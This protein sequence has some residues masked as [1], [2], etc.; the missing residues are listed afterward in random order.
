MHTVSQAITFHLC[1]TIGQ[2]KASDKY[3]SVLNVTVDNVSKAQK[4]AASFWAKGIELQQVIDEAMKCFKAFFKW[5]HIEILRLSDENVS[6]DLNK[7]TQQDIEFIAQFLQSFSQGIQDDGHTYLE[8]VGQYLKEEKLTQPV[9]RSNNRWYSF[10][11]E[12]QDISSKVPEILFIDDQ[13]S[14]I[15]TF[16]TLSDS[17]VD[18]FEALCSS[19]FTERCVES[20]D[21]WKV[22][23]PKLS[24]PRCSFSQI[25][26]AAD[27]TSKADKTY[28]MILWSGVESEQQEQQQTRSL[29]FE[30]DAAQQQQSAN[31]HLKAL[32]LEP[33]Q[34]DKTPYQIVGVSFYTAEAISILTSSPDGQRLIQL[35]ISHLEPFL[36][37]LGLA[38]SR[39]ISLG[40]S[41]LSTQ[42]IMNIA[43]PVS[44][45][46]KLTNPNLIHSK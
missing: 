25:E 18:I 16:Q 12:H 10:I 4:N 22:S 35:P 21:T 34:I 44:T 14:L 28:G 27:D 8:K 23:C 46:H 30:F 42:S 6:E 41:C 17:I 5:L 37:G 13:G 33:G 7:T 15:Q 24:K 39:N 36:S 40:S 29:Y 1:E 45:C 31:D 19:D 26:Y 3:E 11:E 32:W 20:M 43:G 2:I 38:D 9:D